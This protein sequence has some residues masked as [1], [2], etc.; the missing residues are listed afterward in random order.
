ML[1]TTQK[2]NGLIGAQFQINKRWQ[3]R[4]EM[5]FIGNRKSYLLSVNYRFLGFKIK[6]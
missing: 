3:I 1:R 6:N 2:W 4:S 5:G